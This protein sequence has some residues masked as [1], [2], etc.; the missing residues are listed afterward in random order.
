MTREL[1]IDSLEK[2]T[3]FYKSNPG[4]PAPDELKVTIFSLNTVEEL[5]KMARV[6]GNA[7]KRVIKEHDLF[8][9][10][11]EFGG[12]ILEFCARRSN[13]CRKL[14]K[15]VRHVNE[16]VIPGRVVPAHDEEIVEWDCDSILEE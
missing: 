5:G 13:I 12:I 10:S 1:F 7:C 2:L 3:S 4:V 15:G 9:L 11:R 8:Y 16:Q 14:V 6:L